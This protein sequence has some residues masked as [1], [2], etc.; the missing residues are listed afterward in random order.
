M[1]DD[2]SQEKTE[3]AT[4]KRLR[5]ARDKGQVPKSKDVSQVAVL[6]LCFIAMAASMSYMAGEF[7][8]YFEL[9]FKSIGQNE[10]TWA[11]VYELGKLGTFTMI[12]TLLP[13]LLTGVVVGYLAGLLQVGAIFTGDP[14]TPKPERLNPI[15]GLKN[16]FK[17]TVLIE[18][19]KNIAKIAVVFYL[20]YTSIYKALDAVI[21]SSR[22]DMMISAGIT[23]DIITEFLVKVFI[24]FIVISGLDYAL[25]RWDFM[26]NM[27]MSKDEVKREYKQDEGDPAVKGE[28]KRLHREMAFGDAKQ[29]VKKADVVVT[30]PTHVAC[31]LQYDKAE[32]ASPTL[33]MKGQRKFAEWM[34]EI[35]EA[36]GVPVI[37][38]IPL[39]WSLLHLEIGEE[40]PEEL[41]EAVAEVLTLVYEMKN[42]EKP[43][44]PQNAIFV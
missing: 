32:M 43:K 42:E 13:I 14:L 44:D 10:I 38:N 27:R 39:A 19:V 28:R 31:A 24:C 2:S 11:V 1:A 30:N 33:T 6:V 16:M 36:E 22:V 25:Q 17:V 12:K 4:P 20:A 21:Q 9:C 5:E 8:R 26:K 37:R 34:I 18:L 15:E 7:K 3:D 23:S 41:Y 35:A 40:I 29:A